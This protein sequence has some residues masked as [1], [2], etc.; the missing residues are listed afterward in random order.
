MQARELVNIVGR[1]EE[2]AQFQIRYKTLV[3]ACESEGTCTLLDETI[4]QDKD[5]FPHTFYRKGNREYIFPKQNHV[6]PKKCEGKEIVPNKG[7]IGHPETAGYGIKT[8]QQ[9]ATY[10]EALVKGKLRIEYIDSDNQPELKVID[11]I[12]D[13]TIPQKVLDVMKK[14]VP[15]EQTVVSGI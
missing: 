13:L 7:Y 1:F 8:N 4:E 5:I 2:T 15:Q 14:F 12:G 9:E 6:I 3:D 10:D 11:A